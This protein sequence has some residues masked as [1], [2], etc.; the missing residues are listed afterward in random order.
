MQMKT[1]KE[2]IQD[3]LE[4]VKSMD[5]GHER[6]DFIESIYEHL[7]YA[8]NAKYPLK[9]IR[10]YRDLLTKLIKTFGH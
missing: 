7:E 6:V 5:D 2:F 1:S 4:I 10:E 9:Q 8:I 3:T